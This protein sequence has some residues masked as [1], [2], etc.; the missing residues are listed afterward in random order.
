MNQFQ[1]SF[2]SLSEDNSYQQLC[3]ESAQILVI[4]PGN[5]IES[6]AI[7][8]MEKYLIVETSQLI[9]ETVF[10]VQIQ[11]TEMLGLLEKVADFGAVSFSKI[12]L[13]DSWHGGHRMISATSENH[14]N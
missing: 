2:D 8:K 11:I 1:S 3:T 12:H 14:M 6:V 9:Y 7:R 5:K 10:F 13:L 4:Y